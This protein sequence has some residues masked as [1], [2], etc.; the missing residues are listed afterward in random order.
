MNQKDIAIETLK[1]IKEIISSS[2]LKEKYYAENSQIFSRRRK[3]SL[4]WII[5]FVLKKSMKCYDLRLSELQESF[6]ISD[7][8]LPTKQAVS[9]ARSKLSWEIFKDILHEISKIFLSENT[10]KRSWNGYQIYAI[11]GSDCHLPTNKET[12]EY[13]GN[14][15]SKKLLPSAGATT[16]T[17]TDILNGIILDAVIAP[18]KTSERELAL[19][20][21]NRTKSYVDKEKGIIL[22]DR[23]YPSYDFLGYFY[24]N[25]MKFVMRVK[26]AFTKMRTPERKEGEVYLRFRNKMRTLRT[27]KIQLETGLEEYLV[28]NLTKEEM[29][30]ENFRELYFLRWPIEGKYQELK[31]RLMLEE[32]SGKTTNNIQQDYY[33]CLIL[34]NISAFVKNAADE[35]IKKEERKQDKKYQSNRNYVTGCMNHILELFLR[36]TIDLSVKIEHLIKK[37]KSKRSQI[38]PN[39]KYERNTYLNRRKHHINYKPCI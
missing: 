8:D 39:R 16:S 7:E 24:D 32:F 23:G 2:D 29:P 31:N 14:I 11:D 20:H 6:G 10:E 4:E 35:E 3:I 26:E 21:L 28:T 17:M 38:R 13:F 27:V 22:C 37:A 34:S 25:E 5:S 12:I 9:K 1:K 36:R 30:Y 19:E 18:Y 15:A 33:A